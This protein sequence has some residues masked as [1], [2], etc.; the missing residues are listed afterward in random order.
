MGGIGNRT[1]YIMAFQPAMTM[2]FSIGPM[3]YLWMDQQFLASRPKECHLLYSK[4][5]NMPSLKKIILI[6][7]FFTKPIE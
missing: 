6:I 5:S 1:R 3:I 7:I 2:E 4:S